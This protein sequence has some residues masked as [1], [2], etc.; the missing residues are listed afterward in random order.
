MIILYCLGQPKS[1][2]KLK[3]IQRLFKDP[4]PPPLKFKDFQDCAIPV[5]VVPQID[6]S[7]FQV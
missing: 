4:P 5:K 6:V 2:K 7:L 1:I 3:K